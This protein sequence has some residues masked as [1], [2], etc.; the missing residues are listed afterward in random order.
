MFHGLHRVSTPGLHK[1]DL[2]HTVYL[3]LFKHMMDWVEGFLK[4]HARLQAVDDA[5]N[6]LPV[7]PGFFV[8]KKAY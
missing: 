3:G 8:P 7:Y 1:P 5:W 2:L 4:K 6:A